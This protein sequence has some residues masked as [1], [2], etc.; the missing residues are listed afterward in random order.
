MRSSTPRARRMPP[1]GNA[2]NPLPPL[3]AIL[4]DL[5]GTLV[6]SEGPGID[7]LY[8]EALAAGARI[9][10]EEAHRHFR[11]QRMA[12]SVEWIGAR[13]PRRPD[14]FAP[15]FTA[16]IRAAQARRFRAGLA[17]MPGALELVRRL[18]LPHAV[19]TNG[20]REKAELTL[21]LTGLLP[22]FEGRLFCAYEVGSFKPEPGLFEHAARA[23]G[24]PPTDCAVVEDSLPGVAAGIAAGMTVF[25]LMAPG[26]LPPGMQSRVHAI[27]DLT[28]LDRLL[29]G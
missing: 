25:S 3:A 23:L 20:P 13:L 9:T 24:V 29:H 5:D 19:A 21:G 7:V 17:P 4:F 22:H 2:L 11:G 18:R 27:D 8:E 14:D 12:D 16:R 28:V 15:R 26:Q 6:D 10:H 1:E